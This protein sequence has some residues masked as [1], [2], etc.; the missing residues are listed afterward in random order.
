MKTR[1]RTCVITELQLGLAVCGRTGLRVLMWLLSQ[2]D[3]L[4]AARQRFL[5]LL[6]GRF[7]TRWVVFAI[8]LWMLLCEKLGRQ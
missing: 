6:H 4:K 2:P 7:L 5:A 1:L 3:V 8:T